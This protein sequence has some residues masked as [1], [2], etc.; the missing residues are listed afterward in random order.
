MHLFWDC[1]FV[2]KLWKDLEDLIKKN[3]THC[4][5]FVFTKQLVLFGTVENVLTDKVIDFILLITKFY[6]YRCTLQDKLPNLNGFCP[7][8]EMQYL[9]ELYMS[10]MAG[11]YEKFTRNWI[12]Y[13]DLFHY[14]ENE[15]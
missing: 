9:D 4:D 6:I 13:Q 12:M 1:P 3:S 15:K 2:S 14:I 10:K 8:F 11:R 5:K 7:Y